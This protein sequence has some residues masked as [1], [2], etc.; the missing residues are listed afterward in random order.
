MKQFKC[1]G[2]GRCC[3]NVLPR[4]IFDRECPGFKVISGRRNDTEF[5]QKTRESALGEGFILTRDDIKNINSLGLAKALKI[6]RTI[7]EKKTKKTKLSIAIKRAP[8]RMNDGWGWACCFLNDDLK[9]YIYPKRPL[10]CQAYPFIVMDRKPDASIC[11]DETRGEWGDYAAT[12]AESMLRERYLNGA[13]YFITPLSQDEIMTR[14]RQDP[15]RLN[16]DVV[17]Y[18]LGVKDV[19]VGDAYVK[20]EQLNMKRWEEFRRYT[21]GRYSQ[22]FYSGTV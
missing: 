2:C 11:L 14:F 6:A 8:L 15:E 18:I 9:C 17:S 1:S 4:Y 16:Q 20:V 22:F 13:T 3:V 21:R 10:M 7:M 19:N 12:P 5:I